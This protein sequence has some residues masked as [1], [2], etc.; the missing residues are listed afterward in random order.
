M[1]KDTLLWKKKHMQVS[2]NWFVP[3]VHILGLDSWTV[4]E[5]G[6]HVTMSCH[7]QPSHQ[8]MLFSGIIEW[9]KGCLTPI[10]V[11]RAAMHQSILMSNATYGERSLDLSIDSAGAFTIR[12]LKWDNAGLYTCNFNRYAN[13]IIQL[14]LKGM[15]NK[16]ISPAK[17]INEI[18]DLSPTTLIGLWTIVYAESLMIWKFP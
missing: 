4:G 16:M 18:F 9:H 15:W 3:I 11:A 12:N 17:Y 5:I 14:Y 1:N 8:N 2:L 6:N 13:K 7:V 10:L